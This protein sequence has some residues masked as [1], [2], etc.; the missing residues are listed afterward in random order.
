MTAATAGQPGRLVLPANLTMSDM[1]AGSAVSGNAAA[2][3][4][5]AN[6]EASV[7]GST[8]ATS[9]MNTLPVAS[10]QAA[11]SQ[12]NQR[13]PPAERASQNE[14]SA[15]SAGSSS[16]SN[17]GG[18]DGSGCQED[19]ASSTSSVADVLPASL[20]R[21]SQLGR[22]Q[23]LSWL[24]LWLR[25]RDGVPCEQCAE[26]NRNLLDL[27]IAKLNRTLVQGQAVGKKVICS[28]HQSYT[29]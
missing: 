26:A 2:G 27:A 23:A 17:S 6:G 7:A 21:L 22:E 12:Q 25:G 18:P 13:Q 16:D 24:D 15:A 3:S 8:Q 28:V 9:I 5:G 19:S 1:P 11:P 29:P 10:N 14:R 20:T 4:A